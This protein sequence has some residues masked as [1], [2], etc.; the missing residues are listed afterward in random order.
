MSQK[1]IRIGSSQGITI[2]K[3]EIDALGLSLGDEVD[4]TL[5]PVKKLK[6]QKLMSEYD[7]FIEQYGET[8]KNLA[9]R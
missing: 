4:Y 5:K 7:K 9:S 1:L 8:L 2:P 6:H 3:K